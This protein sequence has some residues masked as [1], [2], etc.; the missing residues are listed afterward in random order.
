MADKVPVIL[1]RAGD[2]RGA[3]LEEQLAKRLSGWPQI[4]LHVVPHLYDLA[5]DGPGVQLFRSIPGDVIVLARLYPRSAFWVLNAHRVEGRLG[6]TSS[7]PDE[8]PD[9]MATRAKAPGGRERT[10]WCFDLRTHDRPEPYVEAIARLVGREVEGRAG[11]ADVA[12]AGPFHQ[13]DEPAQPRWYPVIDYDR[14]TNCLECLNFCLFGVYGLDEAGAIVAEE[15]D[16]C[17]PGCPAC[18]RICPAGA[19]MFPD[20]HDPALAGDPEASAAGLKLDLS[21]LFAGV[22]PAQLAA[23]ERDRALADRRKNTTSSLGGAG[24]QPAEDD[25]DRLVDEVDELDL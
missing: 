16:A 9:E 10:L 24:Q 12:A 22:D 17:R 19:I 7:L 8:E 15:P 23:A 1:S 2:G 6:R 18:A 13:V 3:G 4:E 25:L 11:E 5:A 14:C 20:H 21:Q